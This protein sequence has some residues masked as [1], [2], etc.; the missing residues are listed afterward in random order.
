MTETEKPRPTIQQ[1]QADAPDIR[2]AANQ[3]AR[4]VGGTVVEEF[5]RHHRDS[6]T[7]VL[8]Q[9]MNADRMLKIALRCLRTT[10][11]LM[12]CTVASLFGAVITCAQLGLEPN[13]PQGH[14]FLIPFENKRKNIVEVQIVIGYKGLIDLARRS[15]QIASISSHPVYA[16]DPFDVSYGTDESISHKP[17]LD[18]PRGAIIGFYA[19]AKL[20]GG[21]TQFEFMSLSEV[22]A[23]RDKSQGYK[24]A[25]FFAKQGED[26]NTPWFTNF[27]E[28]GR[29]TL[30]RRLC[31]YLPMSIEL[32][33]AVALDERASTSMAQDLDN[34][35]EGEFFV[36]PTDDP[37]APRDEAGD[38]E[39]QRAEP[40][41]TPRARRQR[42]VEA[43]SAVPPVAVPQEREP[44]PVERAANH[45]F[46]AEEMD[47]T[48]RD[49]PPPGRFQ[50]DD[51][52]DVF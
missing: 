20:I 11:K 46:K 24:S 32:A 38:G 4:A 41:P 28:M 30:I 34:V 47:Q 7:A 13:T 2:A 16:N 22:E 1:P 27:P 3:V 26:P 9:H 14:I 6:I 31:K 5:F 12:G 43:P 49:E 21:G 45:D 36:M 50:D 18:G 52:E 19:V 33:G 15:G 8:P 35:L 25:K 29:K 23:I 37:E 48:Y 44:V 40:A 17:K 42:A 10:P 39:Q 51:G